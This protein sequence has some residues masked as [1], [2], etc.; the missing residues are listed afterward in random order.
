MKAVWNAEAADMPVRPMS[1][2]GEIQGAALGYNTNSVKNSPF[3]R[4]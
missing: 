3:Y 2:I 4:G 1:L